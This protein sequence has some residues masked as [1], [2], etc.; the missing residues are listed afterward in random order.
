MKRTI[1]VLIGGLVFLAGCNNQADK[2][3]AKWKGPSYRIAFDTRQT[4]PDPSGITLP[5]I[6]YTANPHDLERRTILVVRFDTAGAKSKGPVSDQMTMVATDIQGAAGALSADY[7]AKADKGLA[8]ILAAYCLKGKIHI[9][10]MLA[11]SS[12]TPQAADAELDAKRMSDW[13]PLDIDFKN[14]HPKC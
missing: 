9:K 14:P 6:T 12:L 4:P 7:M 11:K 2:G 1:L 3:P 13:L 5:V 10:V 8:K